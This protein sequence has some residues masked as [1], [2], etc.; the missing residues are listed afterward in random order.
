[1]RIAVFTSEFPSVSQTFVLNQIVGLLEAG[2]EVHIYANRGCAGGPVHEDVK[3]YELLD[4]ATWFNMPRNRIVRALGS[5]WIICRLTLNGPHRGLRSARWLVGGRRMHAVQGTIH[6]ARAFLRNQQRFDVVYCH[7]GGTGMIA[8]RLKKLVLITG[9]LV[10]VFHGFD[11]TKFIERYGANVYAELLQ[12]GD[13]FLPISETWKA[14][15]LEL[16]AAPNKVK[17]HRMGVDCAKFTFKPR[18]LRRGEAIRIITVA[19]LMK[20]KGIE[21]SIR[22]VARLVGKGYPIEYEIVG[23][24]PLRQSLAAVIDETGCAYRIRL[25]GP[26]SH[27]EVT[28]LLEEAH[29]ML[30]TS[31]TDEEGDQEGIPVAL[32]EAMAMGI[33]VV[34]TYHSGISELVADGVTGILVPER[35]VE[36]IAAAVENLTDN[37]QL[38]PEMARAA[39]EKIEREYNIKLLNKQLVEILGEHNGGSISMRLPSTELGRSFSE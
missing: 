18:S 16:G 25:L 39:R 13:L 3:R 23:D 33:P 9:R 35:D 37:A 8:L 29:L 19:R 34:S 7:F 32:M 4:R 31:V 20:K 21:Y 1:V 24:G 17:V 36:A 30:L 2:H 10:I 26:R 11:I 28:K 22:A 5:A 6:A 12:E 38:W 15:L 27:E 14:R